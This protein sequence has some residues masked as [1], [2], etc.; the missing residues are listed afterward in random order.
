MLLAVLFPHIDGKPPQPNL[1]TVMSSF[2]S[3]NGEDSVYRRNVRQM[4]GE[5]VERMEIKGSREKN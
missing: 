4:W 2:F 3:F 1:G 5:E